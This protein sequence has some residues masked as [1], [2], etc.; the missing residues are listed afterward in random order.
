VTVVI[1]DRLWPGKKGILATGTVKWFN[2]DKG[3]AFISQDDSSD[4]VFVHFS[5][6]I[7]AGRGRRNLDEV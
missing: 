6:I 5:T 7:G 4:N 1:P 2:G 3:F